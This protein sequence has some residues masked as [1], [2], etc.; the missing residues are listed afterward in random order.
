MIVGGIE[1][2]TEEGVE[3]GLEG[4]IEGREEG[5]IEGGKGKALTTYHSCHYNKSWT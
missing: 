3:G 5:R 1:G 4:G 2:V